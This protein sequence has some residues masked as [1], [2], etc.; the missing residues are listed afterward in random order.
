MSHI[1]IAGLQLELSVQDNLYLIKKEIEKVKRRF[2][3]VDMV[4]VG[5]LAGYGPGLSQAEPANSRFEQEFCELASK[6]GLWLLP[7]SYYEQKGNKIFNTAPVI[8]PDGMVETRCRKL[9]PFL[10]YEQGVSSGSEFCLFEVPGAGCFGVSICYDGW[11]PEVTRT[12]ATMGAEVILHPTLT[13]TID[14]DLELAIARTNAAVGQC[15]FVD[16]NIAGELGFGRSIVCGP[17]G[18]VIHQA[19]PGKE[20]IAFEVDFQQLRRSRER[21]VLGL[22][23]PLKSFRDSSLKFPPY[24]EGAATSVVLQDLGPLEVP[25]SQLLRAELNSL[26]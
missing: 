1:G 11:F 18:Q 10:P 3:W 5:E 6:L 23:Q 22:G 7:G 16:I 9:F 14:R 26:D 13:N 4:V 24:I 8:N 2:P 12:L 19:G 15:Y 17:E 25:G 20:I 21:G